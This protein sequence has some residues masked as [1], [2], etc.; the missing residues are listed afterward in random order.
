MLP[1][2][3]IWLAGREVQKA[4][5]LA[6]KLQGW[7]IDTIDQRIRTLFIFSIYL[8]VFAEPD[9]IR[10]MRLPQSELSHGFKKLVYS[11]SQDN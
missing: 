3:L 2:S 8:W 4:Q 9:R 7:N 11:D 1:A 10:Q 6:A 5:R